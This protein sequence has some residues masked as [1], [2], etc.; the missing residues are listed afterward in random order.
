MAAPFYNLL[1][2]PGF[3]DLVRR[4]L[5]EDVDLNTIGPELILA[6]VLENDRP[7]W[8]VL[9]EEIPW[10]G[11]QSSGALALNFS[12]VGIANPF[13]PASRIIVVQKITIIN[14]TAA[15]LNYKFGMTNPRITD[16][17]NQCSPRD[18]RRLTASTVRF[19]RQQVADPLP[20]M[21][22]IP[23]PANDSRTFTVNFMP[24]FQ[25]ALIV[26]GAVVNQVVTATFEGYERVAR[27]EEVAFSS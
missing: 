23:V 10:I 20:Q 11:S 16:G 1:Q 4:L 21:N 13:V 3:S 14:A 27:P 9:K 26:M 2:R 22:G 15:P 19:F 5:G 17:D 25:A 6:L 7:E 8:G 18:G 24:M 12:I